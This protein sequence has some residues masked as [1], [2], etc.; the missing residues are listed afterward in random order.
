MR[1]A[2]ACAALLAGCGGGSSKPTP[3]THQAPAFTLDVP[4]GFKATAEMDNDLPGSKLMRFD[5]A[6]PSD[7]LL[8]AWEPAGGTGAAR[9]EELKASG[10]TVTPGGA[11]WQQ[12]GGTGG[13][14]EA[15]LVVGDTLVECQSSGRPLDACKSLRP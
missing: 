1:A 4:P 11:V 12:S 15:Y 8:L 10:G 13:I 9:M 3:Y 5:G 2:L 6:H 7:E 14:V